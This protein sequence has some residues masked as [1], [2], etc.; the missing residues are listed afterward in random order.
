MVLYRV[1]CDT[2]SYKKRLSD[3]PHCYVLDG[4]IKLDFT[5]RW[6]WCCGCTEVVDAEWFC[7]EEEEMRL[8]E[9]LLENDLGIPE[10]REY[11]E[12][13]SV[14]RRQWRKTRQSPPH[15]LHCGSTEFLQFQISRQTGYYE[16]LPHPG[17]KG[18][19]ILEATGSGRPA[20]CLLYTPEGA[21][22]VK[23]D[24]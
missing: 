14:L 24:L 20:I 12:Q 1:S 16:P 18:Q 3:L 9:D 19:L 23:R 15:C 8:D 22:L 6:A 11:L 21:F 17:C 2:C 13:Q 7:S 10:Y 4:D 5:T